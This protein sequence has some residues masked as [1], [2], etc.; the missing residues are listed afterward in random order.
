VIHEIEIQNFGCIHNATVRLTR[1]HA[2]VG[3][4]GA[5]KTTLLDAITLIADTACGRMRDQP[6]RPVGTEAATLLATTANDVKRLVRLIVRKTTDGDPFVREVV[7]C[8]QSAPLNCI[9][10][11]STRWAY[12]E[13][14][15]RSHHGACM[16]QCF[17][18]IEALADPD[19]IV[20]VEHPENYL[21]PGAIADMMARFRGI[22]ER[23]QVLITTHSPLVLNEMRPDEVTLVRRDSETSPSVFMPIAETPNFADRSR[24]YALGEL[25]VSYLDKL[26]DET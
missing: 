6:W 22:A 23:A 1:L 24:V 20:L 21:Y 11:D 14:R 26:H 25:W 5:G 10:F 8:G 7:H 18:N 16:L 4:N 19:R 13:P 12:D 3:P 9:R 17:D 2:F 15:L